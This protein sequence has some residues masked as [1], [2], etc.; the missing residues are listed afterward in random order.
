MPA[1]N[2]KIFSLLFDIGRR[3][4]EGQQRF[5]MLHFQTLR[6]IKEQG[7]PLMQ[8]VARHLCI[9]PPA[10][11]LL[12]EGLAREGLVRRVLDKRDRRVV[13]VALSKGGKSFLV[14]GI[15][16]RM[17]KLERLFAVLTPKERATLIAILKKIAAGNR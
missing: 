9:T 4:R 11:T 13:R 14:R 10:A 15:R 12:I 8:D 6:Y 17:K 1:N 7:R 3:M 5:S 2:A 16:Q